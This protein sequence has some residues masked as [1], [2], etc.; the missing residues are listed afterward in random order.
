MRTIELKS[1]GVGRYDDVSPFIITDNKLQLKIE[2][3]AQ[4][5][6]FYFIGKNGDRDV[7]RL[8]PSN[9]ELT[10]EK[11]T[12][13]ELRADV[14]HYFKGEIIKTYQVEPLLLK[15]VD[16]NL[17]ADPVIPALKKELESA[18]DNIGALEKKNTKL[19]QVTAKLTRQVEALTNF[20]KKCIS[21]IPYIYDLKIEEEN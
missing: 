9:G 12:A 17:S 19:E 16:G 14:K 18:K 10:L 11:F 2:L 7:K 6:E 3:P 5:G 21:A 20:A 15:E 4:S 8:I 1:Y 13:G